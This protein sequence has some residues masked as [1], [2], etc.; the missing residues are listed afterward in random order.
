MRLTHIVLTIKNCVPVEFYTTKQQAVLSHFLCDTVMR[1][2]SSQIKSLL[3][4]KL[5]FVMS[6]KNKNNSQ[7]NGGIHNPQK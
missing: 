2:M 1:V 5:G 7:W 4:M 3:V 6:I